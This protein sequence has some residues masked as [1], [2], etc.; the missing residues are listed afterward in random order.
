MSISRKRPGLRIV[1]ALALLCAGVALVAYMQLCGTGRPPGV[2][3]VGTGAAAGGTQ[4]RFAITGSVTGLYP[5]ASLPLVLTVANPEP[6]TIDV[7][8]IT[9]TVGDASAGCKAAYLSVASFNG[10]L[11][12]SAHS[13]A[14]VAVNATLD[15][16]AAD[17]C[18]GAVFPLTYSG[19]ASKP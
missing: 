2:S 3:L 14:T 12:V 4:G 15:H 13:H 11:L 8:S 18:Q 6:F 9:T 10:N 19:L 16:S 1:T 7:T 17:A 5:G